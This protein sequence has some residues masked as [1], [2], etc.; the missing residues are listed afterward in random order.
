MVTPPARRRSIV[1]GVRWSRKLCAYLEKCARC[2]IAELV[3]R[4]RVQRFKI[5]EAIAPGAQEQNGKRKSSE[6]LLALKASVDRDEGVIA[7]VGGRLE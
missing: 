1:T 5:F 3:E 7:G 2:G 4:F 6:V